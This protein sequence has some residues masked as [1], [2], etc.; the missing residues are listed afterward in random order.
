MQNSTAKLNIEEDQVYEDIFCRSTL[1][2][3]EKQR[4]LCRGG[5]AL[6]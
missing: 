6:F 2:I 3:S 4:T 5:Q 1:L